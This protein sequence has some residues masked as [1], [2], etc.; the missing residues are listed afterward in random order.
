MLWAM[1]GVAFAEVTLV[2]LGLDQ[3][4]ALDGAET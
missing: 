1:R 4:A 2:R 3:V